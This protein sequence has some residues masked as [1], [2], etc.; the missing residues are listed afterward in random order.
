M[1]LTFW[2]SELVDEYILNKKTISLFL[3]GREKKCSPFIIAV[4]YFAFVLIFLSINNFNEE[5]F[6]TAVKFNFFTI[7]HKNEY[8]EKWT[9]SD[10]KINYS[11]IR[12]YLI[13]HQYFLE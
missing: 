2:I 1:F 7:F 10:S 9:Q 3:Y 5:Y 11:S 8:E 12:K 6:F 13:S 4:F